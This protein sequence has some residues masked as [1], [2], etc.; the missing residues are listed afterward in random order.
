[1]VDWI[2]QFME[3]HGYLGV[4]M[5][6]TLENLFPPIPSEVILPFGGFL[7][8]Y[9]SLS[10][11]GVV[12]LATSG[13]VTGAIL[14]YGAG[15][16]LGIDKVADVVDKWGGLLRLKKEDVFKTLEWFNK[17]GVWTVLL[18]RMIPLV[19][20]LISIPAG[21]SG[22]N[23]TLFVSFTLFGTFTWNLLLVTAGVILGESWSDILHYM[24]MYS[25]LTYS[26]T[27][28]IFLLLMIWIYLKRKKLQKR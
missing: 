6:M 4:F 1:M 3:Q 17:Y 20:S 16:F 12:I 2:I 18:C 19:R 9:T 23:F 5:L 26:F 22:M 14:L 28:F 25:A 13:S 15:Y 10:A 27:G 7:T 21:M 24:H 11:L 8:T